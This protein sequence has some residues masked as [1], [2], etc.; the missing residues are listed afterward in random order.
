MGSDSL[1][2][3]LVDSIQNVSYGHSISLGWV[4]LKMIVFLLLIIVLILLL[5][6]VYKKWMKKEGFSGIENI[7][8]MNQVVLGPGRVILFVRLFD[9]VLAILQSGNSSVVLNRWPY[10]K[11]QDRIESIG[12]RSANIFETLLKNKLK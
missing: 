12:N 11:I 5:A 8:L 10:E 6:F 9:E 4:L 3:S 7:H 1:Q 2:K